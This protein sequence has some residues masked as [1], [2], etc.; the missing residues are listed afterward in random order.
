MELARREAV[1]RFTS[2][3]PSLRCHLDFKFW[4]QER[5]RKWAEHRKMLRAKAERRREKR[6]EHLGAIQCEAIKRR[7]LQVRRLAASPSLTPAK[8]VDLVSEHQCGI[9]GNGARLCY[10]C[11][12]GNSS[13]GYGFLR[14]KPRRK[15]LTPSRWY[16]SRGR[17]GVPWRDVRWP[18]CFVC[19]V[20]ELRR[21]VKLAANRLAEVDA[22]HH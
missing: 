6:R 13:A 19:D 10:C 16:G 12:S 14:W 20:L 22:D 5:K 4:L 21:E 18:R 8:F 7:A 2:S 9:G 3:L 15:S 17:P 11:R 1:S